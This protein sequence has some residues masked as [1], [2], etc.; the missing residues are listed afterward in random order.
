MS[1]MNNESYYSMI[2][3]TFAYLGYNAKEGNTLQEIIKQISDNSSILNTSG[4]RSQ[5]EIIQNA[6]N[7]NK[8]LGNMVLLTQSSTSGRYSSGTAAYVFRDPAGSHYVSYCG[9]GDGEWLDNAKGMVDASTPQQEEAAR[10]FDDVA[11]QYGWTAE[12]NIIVTGHSKGGNKAQYITMMSENQHLID[13]CY[14]VDGQGFSEAA[15][16][17]FKERL[18]ED[19]ETVIHKMH[20]ING[21]N[22]Y[23]NP[24]GISVIKEENTTYIKTNGDPEDFVAHHAIEHMFHKDVNGTYNGSMNSVTEAGDMSKFAQELSKFVMSL[25]PKEREAVAMTIMQIAEMSEGLVTGLDGTQATPEQI[26]TFI[27]EGVPGIV[28]IMLKSEHGRNLLL[29]IVSSSF[30]KDPVKTI[31]I[32]AIVALCAPALIK[33][34]VGMVIISKIIKAGTEKLKGFGKLYENVVNFFEEINTKLNEFAQRIGN[35]LRGRGFYA[36]Y[37]RLTVDTGML[38]TTKEELYKIQRQILDIS[39]SVRQIKKEINFGLLTKYAFSVAL[40]GDARDIN[41]VGGGIGSLA[42][43]IDVVSKLYGN[44]EVEVVSTYEEVAAVARRI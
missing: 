3:N 23:V 22:D 18:G 27:A 10:F 41:K 25:P 39:E 6:I 33:V 17:Q 14:S 37:S 1:A 35:A 9:T 21:E 20:G 19:Y 26:I 44:T 8:D 12:D 43:G 7:S 5:F 24:L 28:G 34:G 31:G 32:I 4:K 2:L 11:K 15:I 38:R 29:K 30:K 42:E 40:A 16:V 36:D 13:H